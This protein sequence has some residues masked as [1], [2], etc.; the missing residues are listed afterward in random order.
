M[1]KKESKFFYSF[2]VILFVLTVDFIW[3]SQNN[4]PLMW[5]SALHFA[6]ILKFRNFF[7]GGNFSILN[8]LKLEPFYP[9]LFYLLENLFFLFLPVTIKSAKYLNV[10]FV[11][12]L[13]GITY[14][15]SYEILKKESTS[16][17]AA[18]ILVMSPHIWWTSRDVMLEVGTLFFMVLTLYFLIKT[19]NFKEKKFSI[20]AG[21]SLGLSLIFKWTE[22]FILFFPI[23]YYF[24]A[25]FIKYRKDYKNRM[26]NFLN[27]LISSLII[28]APWYGANFKYLA[29]NFLFLSQGLGQIEGD[30][31]RFTFYYF[32]YYLRAL[33]GHHLFIFLFLLFLLGLYKW[34]KSDVSYK[35]LII[36]MILG[37]YVV[38]TLF[39]NK[40]YRHIIYVL[41][42]ISIVISYFV[43][44]I[45]SKWMKN[46]L[47]MLTLIVAIFQSLMVSFDIFPFLPEKCVL[48][49]EDTCSFRERILIPTSN[50]YKTT[51]KEYHD[52]ICCY[53]RNEFG[54]WG[55]PKWENW[56]IGEIMDYIKNREN[57]FFSLGLVFDH[58]YLNV[59]SFKDYQMLKG[60]NC[61]IWRI[62]EKGDL[63]RFKYVLIK[64][65]NQG[66]FWNTDEN[67]EIMKRL[68]FSR[69]YV[70]LKMWK[71]P[72]GYSLYL[73]GKL[74][75]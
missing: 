75:N 13:F 47:I 55:P 8:F 36:W 71:M 21:I 24:Y 19:E 9:P 29:D 54:I 68:I 14:K 43:F 18:A 34:I 64:D 5:D 73:Y 72:D 4:L 62:A 63:K 51:F 57:G 56:R 26:E 60:I 58:R 30:P 12:L 1:L 61:Y 53:V 10:F 11:L 70:N 27:F 38:L 23:L 40:A 7:T 42:A 59:W 15:F 69:D 37:P 67:K 44:G 52:D 6:N 35:F 20:F 32:T 33:L 39:S 16:L 31:A 65:G 41:P 3:F 46:L 74:R 22:F 50:G 28:F 25:S 66:P 49:H 48:K 17:F 2:L 45:K